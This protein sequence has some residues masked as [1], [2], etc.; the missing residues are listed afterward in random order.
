MSQ[1]GEITPFEVHMARRSIGKRTIQESVSGDENHNVF[2]SPRAAT[3]KVMGRYRSPHADYSVS[4]P[5]WG[6]RRQA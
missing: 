5:S 4:F 3:R 6:T 2:T 1:G